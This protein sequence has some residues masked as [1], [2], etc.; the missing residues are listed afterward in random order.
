MIVISLILCF[1]LVGCTFNKKGKIE[2]L[3]EEVTTLISNS[4]YDEA[5][6]KYDE[7]L[8]LDNSS[9]NVDGKNNIQ[10]LKYE[11]IAEE[12]LTEG[13][14][15]TAVDNYEK[16][17]DIKETEGVKSILLNIKEEQEAVIQVQTFYDELYNIQKERLRSGISVNPTDMEYIIK[18]LRRLTE[19]FEEIDD[20]KDTDIAR[21]IKNVKKSLHYE[22]YMINVDSKLHD[23]SGLSEALGE[24][25][26]GM[27]M[28][29]T[30]TVANTR[31]SLNDS[32]DGIID[33]PIPEKYK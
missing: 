10:I 23:D 3:K 15:E 6:L 1:S 28:V 20:S 32:I 5:M 26:T 16:I 14:V 7:I 9:I 29:N 25:D 12:A 22:L 4:K 11:K 24:L 13:D 18:D 31:N 8:S 30:L 17:L 33:M 21:H 2:N 27:K 19:D